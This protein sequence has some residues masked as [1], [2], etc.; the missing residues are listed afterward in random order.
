MTPMRETTAIPKRRSQAK[1]ET[2]RVPTKPRRNFGFL[3]NLL[4]AMAEVRSTIWG[5]YP[6]VGGDG[7]A[8]TH[9]KLRAE[10]ILNFMQ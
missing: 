1:L 10:Y 9:G 8:S 6:S 2:T 3:A 5:I 4:L 7:E